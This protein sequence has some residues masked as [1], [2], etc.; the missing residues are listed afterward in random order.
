MASKRKHSSCTVEQ[1]L[2]ALKRLDNG[3]SLTKI[4]AEIGVGKATVSDWKKNRLKIEQFSTTTSKKTLKDR[5][6]VT[7][8]VNEKIDEAVFLWFSQE[9]QK[10]VPISGP[11]IQ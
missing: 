10:G 2:K 1:K 8:S 7:V 3:E 11:L 4:A 9:R 5:H 6:H